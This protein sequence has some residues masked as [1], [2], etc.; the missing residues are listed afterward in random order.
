MEDVYQDV[1]RHLSEDVKFAEWNIATKAVKYASSSYDCSSNS[2]STIGENYVQEMNPIDKLLMLFIA[3]EEQDPIFNWGTNSIGAFVTKSTMF[4]FCPN[5][6][7]VE[8]QNKINEFLT[9]TGDSV[10]LLDA[11]HL[12]SI[13]DVAVLANEDTSYSLHT[14]DHSG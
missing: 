10:S 9:L 14:P 13:H 12:F 7:A 4:D 6:D 5:I 1:V 2:S 8:Y 3:Y 11:A